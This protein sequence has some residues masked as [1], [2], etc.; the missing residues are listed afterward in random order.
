MIGRV[1]GGKLKFEGV[2]AGPHAG[3]KIERRLAGAGDGKLK[4]EGPARAGKMN[5]DWTGWGA[6]N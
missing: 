2:G 3:W 5:F 6:E 4:F 1:G